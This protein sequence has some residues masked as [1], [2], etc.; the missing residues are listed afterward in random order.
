MAS[1]RVPCTRSIHMVGANRVAA[2][3]CKPAISHRIAMLSA[4]PG[5]ERSRRELVGIA[6]DGRRENLRSTDSR[7]MDVC[8]ENSRPRKPGLPRRR[9]ARRGWRGGHA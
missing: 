9:E 3:R 1:G 4:S 5:I 7:W 8:H 2:L 6:D